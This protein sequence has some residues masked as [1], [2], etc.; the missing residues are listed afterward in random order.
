MRS[1]AV[2]PEVEHLVGTENIRLLVQRPTS[3]VY[4]CPIC[5]CPGTSDEAASAVVLRSPTG[6]PYLR[7]AHAACSESRVIDV[8]AETADGQERTVEDSPMLAV[9]VYVPHASGNRRLLLMEP[10]ARISTT[11]QVGDRVDGYLQVLSRLGLAP[12]RTVGQLPPVTPGWRA[13]L[14]DARTGRIVAGQATTTE[15]MFDGPLNQPEPWRLAALAFR[16]VI[17]FSGT[18]GFGE[19]RDDGVALLRQA[20]R[21]ARS[22]LLMGGQVS[23]VVR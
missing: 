5:R 10:S 2:H 11:T 14:P 23:V 4:R 1:V 18:I 12:V 19:N 8:D 6:R 21:A 16:S 9:T 7:L 15:T 17:L 3:P 22:G 20:N 13:Y